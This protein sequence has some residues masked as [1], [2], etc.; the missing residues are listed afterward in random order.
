MCRSEPT[1]FRT[2]TKVSHISATLSS[3]QTILRAANKPLLSAVSRHRCR[4][5]VNT[6]RLAYLQNQ[7]ILLR[8][9]FRPVVDQIY[10]LPSKQHP[11]HP[12]NTKTAHSTIRGN[13]PSSPQPASGMNQSSFLIL[14]ATHAVEERIDLITPG[15]GVLTLT[16]K[17]F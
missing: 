12:E 17:P 2:T 8:N 13:G 15:A 7:H 11:H 3:E 16:Q 14:N 4:L 6:R 1:S 9:F 10:S 5:T